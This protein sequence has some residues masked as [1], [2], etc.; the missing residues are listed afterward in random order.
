MVR[1]FIGPFLLTSGIVLFIIVMQ[2]LWK[3]IDDLVGKGLE[4]HIIAQLIFYASASFVP[5][6]L[7]LG[8]LLSSIM[9][10]GSMG[11]H[12]EMVVLKSAGISLF[13]IIRGAMLFAIGITIF[14]FLF[15]NYA[16]PTANLQF[17]VLLR[18]IVEKK[19]ALNIEEGVFYQEIDGFSIRVG[20]KDDDNRTIHD[21]IIYDHTTG[22]TNNNLLL[23]QKGEM[24]N[25][26]GGGILIMRLFN[27]VQY[28]EMEPKK[29]SAGMYEHLT[30]HFETFEKK[31]DM[32]Q[33]NMDKSDAQIWKNHHQM[34]NLFQLDKAMDTIKMTMVDKANELKK[35]L[36][37]Y[38]TYQKSSL[39]SLAALECPTIQTTV[40][41]IN[42]ES[43]KQDQ[44]I[45]IRRALAFARNA[46]SYIG[47]TRRDKE[48]R[49]KQLDKH[50]IEWHRKFTM[51]VACLI[52][53][54][55]G[56]PMGA[57]TRKGGMGWP[58]LISIL[59]FI[60]LHVFN[61]MGEKMAEQNA[62]SVPFGMWLSSFVLLPI[63]V[64]LSYKAV[65]DSKLFSSEWYYGSFGRVSNKIRKKRQ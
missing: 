57:I 52:M 45:T 53:F 54:F 61:V 55:I 20:Q 63:S 51:S 22:K 37:T 48:F 17:K 12:Y 24:I 43:S 26:E 14:A 64:F 62:I 11:E 50:N 3:Y 47:I 44:L 23:A 33:F 31:F 34:M 42:V 40:N 10:M 6:A 41:L 8:V 38:F 29:G 2:F 5:M 49:I 56:A 16:I 1:S 28:Q 46:K 27:G 21:I 65:N 25:D 35:N 13:R 58:I 19:P 18:D 4:W 9:T 59:F 15:S 32:N 7:P 30:T 39:D 60:I 36:Q